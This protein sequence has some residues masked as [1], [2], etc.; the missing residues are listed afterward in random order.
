V[1]ATLTDG[2]ANM[3]FNTVAVIALV[4]VVALVLISYVVEALRTVPTPPPK[5]PWAPDIQIAY[6]N[7]G[8]V[9]VRY[10]KT[11]SGPNLVLLH[12][13]R[14]HSRRGHYQGFLSLLNHEAT[15]LPTREQNRALIGDEAVAT[16]ND[17]GHFLSLDRPREL[18]DLILRFTA[19]RIPSSGTGT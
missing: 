2:G 8:G 4:D 11:G 16:L 1:P 13:L 18:T 6:A 14:T 15:P 19:G 12:T 3:E 7:L 10:L 9:E 5:L 17:G